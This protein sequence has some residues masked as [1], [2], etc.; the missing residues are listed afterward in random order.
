MKIKPFY[1]IDP[2]KWLLTRNPD[3][4]DAQKKAFKNPAMDEKQI[5]EYVR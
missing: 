3:V 1:K 4:A 2:A 5:E